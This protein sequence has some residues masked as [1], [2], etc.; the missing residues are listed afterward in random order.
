[1]PTYTQA[2]RPVRIATPLEEDVLLLRSMTGVERLGQPFEYELVLLSEKH[3]VDYKEIIGKNVTVSVNKGDKEPRYFNG[4]ISRFGQANYEKRLVEYRATM[5][6]W[7]WLL[8]RS[9]DCRIFQAMS[10]PDILKQIFTDFGFSDVIF[11]LHGT[12]KTWEYCVQYRETTFNFVSRLMEQEGIYYFFKHENGKHTL[13]LC[14]T[15]G[16]HLEFKGYEEL[17]FRLPTEKPLPYESLWS[18][19]EH[20]EVQPGGYHVKEFDFKNPRRTTIGTASMDRSH[21]ASEFEHF[22]YLGEMDAESDGERY[23]KLRLEEWQA[24]HEIYTGEGDARGTCTGVRFTLRGHPRED[25]EKEYLTIGTEFKIESDPFETVQEA[26]NEFVYEAKLTAIPVSEQFRPRRTTSKPLIQGP[27]TAMVVGVKGEEIH[28]DKYGRVKVQFHWDHYGKA[29]ENSSCWVRVA[30]VWAGKQWGSVYTPR[31]GQEVIVEFLE[32]DPDRPIITGRVYNEVALPPYELPAKK[33]ISTTKS[34]ST[35]GGQG[36]NEIRF[37]DNKGEEQLFFHAEKD[38]EIRIKND[39]HEW[40]GNEQHLIV[41]KD[42]FVEVEGKTNQTIKG[43]A[44][45]KTE[46]DLGELVKGAHHAEVDGADHLVVKGDQ[47]ATVDGDVNQKFNKNLNHKTEQK[48]SIEAG[49]D[50]HIKAGTTYAVQAG[51]TVHIKGATT[52]VI[53]GGSQLSLKAGPSFIDIGSG[54]VAISGPMVKV[55]SGGSAASGGGCSVTAPAK[56]EPPDPPGTPKEAAKA[57]PGEKD[58]PPPEP[59]P[60]N[61]TQYSSAA[62]VLKSAAQHGT[63]FCEEC[64]RAAEE[65]AA[66]KNAWVEIQLVGEDGKPIPDEPYR[67]TLPDGSVEEGTLDDKGL[68]RIE[69]FERGECQVTFPELDKEAW[70]PV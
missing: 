61:P 16:S 26:K 53:E 48:I 37:E 23:S 59:T 10:V 41:K 46:G 2:N 28:T 58:E 6:P 63:P 70:E 17:K 44:L 35:K 49:Q 65:E 42:Q 55:N 18:W 27:Q 54:G 47:F 29:D 67:L 7:L 66:K 1:M 45:S 50:A 15:P 38:Q 9:A 52:V 68:A 62:L 69:G 60:P 36:F 21:A 64:A 8:T 34:N 57:D 25:F 24:M 5:V 43:N 11:R 20:H 4:I 12:Y 22:D 32:G 39:V 33:T 31:V 56:A 30:Q 14:D 51:T 3:D 19:V 13:V 40:I